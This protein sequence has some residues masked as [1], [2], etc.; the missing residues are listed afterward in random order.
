MQKGL[1]TSPSIWLISEGRYVT[2]TA[3]LSLIGSPSGPVKAYAV[4][5]IARYL[6]DP[7]PIDVQK[8]LVGMELHFRQPAGNRWRRRI[9]RWLPRFCRGPFR[10]AVIPPATLFSDY[11]S[12]KPPLMTADL[13][14][15]F[16]EAYASLKPF[17]GFHQQLQQIDLNAVEDIFGLCED[18][19]G[20]RTPLGLQGSLNEKADYLLAHV[21]TTVSVRMESVQIAEGLFEMGGFDFTRFRPDR[22]HRLYKYYEKDGAKA[23]LATPEG[24]V[25]F[26]LSDLT[27]I[28]YLQLAEQSIRINHKFREAIQRCMAGSARPMKLMFNS[29]LEIDYSQAALPP[30]F[31]RAF[32][33]H[34]VEA[35]KRDAVKQILNR[36]QIGISFNYVPYQNSGEEKLLTDI[37]VMQDVRALDAL[38]DHLPQVY[39]E[40]TEH[41][42]ITE[43]GKYY[44]LEA[45]RGVRNAQ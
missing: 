23:C 9:R 26:V 38:K 19:A 6:L 5:D 1:E 14:R 15:H 22:S 29:D 21:G 37:S 13:E 8:A 40:I 25:A 7:S 10:D 30:V 44:L 3:E 4:S 24:T 42:T 45:I 43:A 34:K 16:T 12:R 2:D 11:A 41:T 36:M 27:I 31:Q 28:R 33:T 35:N 17:D 20:N 39:S 18:A 32:D